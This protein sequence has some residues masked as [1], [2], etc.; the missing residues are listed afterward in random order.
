MRERLLMIISERQVMQLMELVK[1]FQA[2]LLCA[3]TNIQAK[4]QYN[5]ADE[6][7]NTIANQQS[8]EL[9]VIE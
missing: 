3:P 6:L 5:C 2:I 8:D 7:L 9:K 1:Q 4:N